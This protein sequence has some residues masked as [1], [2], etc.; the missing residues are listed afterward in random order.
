VLALDGP[1]PSVPPG[2]HGV[3]I[4]TEKTVP[5]IEVPPAGS[6]AGVRVR[7]AQEYTDSTEY[8]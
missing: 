5:R 8:R 6:G 1:G 2:L 3:V 7:G 4:D